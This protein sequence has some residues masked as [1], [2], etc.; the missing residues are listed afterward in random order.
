MGDFELSKMSPEHAEIFQNHDALIALLLFVILVT[1]ISS[2]SSGNF[3]Y[4]YLCQPCG[5]FT[6]EY[7]RQP[8]I[9]YKVCEGSGQD[10]SRLADSLLCLSCPRRAQI[11]LVLKHS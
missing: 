1:S 10:C 4:E 5:N 7:L 11:R 9:S 3:M 6:Y 2:T 8:L